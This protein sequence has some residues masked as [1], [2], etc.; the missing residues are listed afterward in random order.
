MR[1]L[2]ICLPVVLFVFSM[3]WTSCKKDNL[4]T[5]TQPDCDTCQTSVCDTA[6]ELS[7]VNDIEP[8]LAATCYDCHGTFTSANG[9]GNVL[10]GYN[11]LIVYVNDGRL[12][13]TITHA[14]DYPPMP[15]GDPKLSDCRIARIDAWIRQGALNN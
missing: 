6:F 1:K 4:E 2:T 5:L 15:D 10:Q 8:I 13:G 9:E 11:N 7:Y 12:M 3:W 14:P